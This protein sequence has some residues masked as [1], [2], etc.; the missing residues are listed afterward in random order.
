MTKITINDSPN[1]I[2]RKIKKCDKCKMR[3]LL[4]NDFNC[5]LCRSCYKEKY[6]DDPDHWIDVVYCDGCN[7]LISEDSTKKCSECFRCVG[8]CCGV[9]YHCQ[10]TECEC[11]KCFNGCCSRCDKP[12]KP[13]KHYYLSDG[14][15]D[16]LPICKKC[17]TEIKDYI[18]NIKSNR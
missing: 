7:H 1:K 13:L 18:N 2:K 5:N 17:K 15:I 6:S 4:I 9:L 8:H 10:S 12:L 14:S 16:E 3:R 11:E